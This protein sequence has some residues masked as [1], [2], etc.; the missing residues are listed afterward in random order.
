MDREE[1]IKTKNPCVGGSIP[2]H[3]KKKSDY[4]INLIVAFLLGRILIEQS[5]SP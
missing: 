4:E 5:T 2:H 1:F 3:K